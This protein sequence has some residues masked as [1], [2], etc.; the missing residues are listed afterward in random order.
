[1]TVIAGQFQPIDFNGDG[2]TDLRWR[3]RNTNAVAVWYMDGASYVSN[4]VIT[5][6]N[7]D[8]A[9]AAPR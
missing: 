8:W 2:K 5:T 7:T 3:N 1:M 4:A 6:A 9:I